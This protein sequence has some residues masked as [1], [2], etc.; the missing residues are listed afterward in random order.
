MMLI[1]LLTDRYPG[2]RLWLSQRLT[3]LVMAAY[4]V[5]SAIYF[6]VIWPA[7][8][9]A[10]LSAV[11]PI[12]WRLLTFIFY[13]CLSMHAWVGV[14]DVLRDY[15]FNKTVRAYMQIIVDMLLL[16]YLGWAGVILWNMQK[17]L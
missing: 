13:A 7:N 1:E 2:M 16:V 15:V 14:R 9:Q 12:W 5:F 3:A 6:I 8:Y 4:I 11:S 10:W 17:V